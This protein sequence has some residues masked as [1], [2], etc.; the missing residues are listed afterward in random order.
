[1]LQAIPFIYISD[2]DFQGIQI[3]QILKYGGSASAWA[4]EIQVCPQLI[5]AGPSKRELLDSPRVYQTEYEKQYRLDYPN[6]TDDLVESAVNKWREERSAHIHRKLVSASKQDRELM[7]GFERLGWLEHE[8]ELKQEIQLMLREPSK[9]RLADLSQ[10]NVRYLRI[11][12]Q[13]KL[14]TLSPIKI[15]GAAR[16][17]P[18]V[19]R[20]PTGERWKALPSQVDIPSEDADLDDDQMRALMEED[21]A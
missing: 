16:V 3:F 9:F 20:S 15:A 12:I 7:K 4:S 2:H 10:V 17:Q 1:M 18:G 13:S 21:L 6:K 11:F 8:Q 19:L 14:D 5:W